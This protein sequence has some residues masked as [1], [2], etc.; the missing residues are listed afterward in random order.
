VPVARQCKQENG[1]A[2]LTAVAAKRPGVGRGCD[3]ADAG[4]TFCWWRMLEALFRQHAA[5]E[6]KHAGCPAE[7]PA[8][9]RTAG[10][11]TV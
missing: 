4:L 6:I 7:G 10:P 8:P 2:L 3:I 11:E 9:H 5:Y 1:R